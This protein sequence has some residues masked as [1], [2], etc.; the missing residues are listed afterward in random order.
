MTS[1]I[2][3]MTSSWINHIYW[4]HFSRYWFFVNSPVIGEFLSQRPV[5]RSFDVF[6]DCRLNKL[7]SKQSRR[8]WFE[9]KGSRFVHVLLAIPKHKAKVCLMECIQFLANLA[10]LCCIYLVI[11][12]QLLFIVRLLWQDC[13]VRNFVCIYPRQIYHD[14]TQAICKPS[15]HISLSD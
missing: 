12:R 9:T 14:N 1:S 8:R 3:L 13:C 5:T 7:L 15:S 2:E 4:K 11:I 10:K 6:F